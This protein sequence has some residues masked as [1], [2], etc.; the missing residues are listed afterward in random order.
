[1]EGDAVNAPDRPAAIG[2]PD[3]LT[4]RLFFALA[5]PNRVKAALESL[6]PAITEALPRAR[7]SA[8]SGLHL[9]TA[10]LGQVRPEFAGDVVEIGETAASAAP[11]RLSLR[12]DGAG[13]FPGNDRAHVLWAGIGGDVDALTGIANTLADSA[14]ESGMRI[15]ERPFH[16]HLTLARLPKPRRLTPEL[17]D[18]VAA[19]AAAAPPWESTQLHCYRS[20][21]TNQGARYTIVRSFQLGGGRGRA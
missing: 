15:E 19:A 5:V 6:A 18:R 14:R 9:T 21:Q 4:G 7:L 13:G 17:L 3:L 10:F 12:L 11:E 16:A 8:A 20:T 2:D 1:M